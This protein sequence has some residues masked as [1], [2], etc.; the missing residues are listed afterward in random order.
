[1]NNMTKQG[2]LVL[3]RAKALLCG[4]LAGAFYFSSWNITLSELLVTRVHFLNG[5]V[6]PP[7]PKELKAKES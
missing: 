7:L 4:V 3:L 5:R 6:Q 2:Y 1:M